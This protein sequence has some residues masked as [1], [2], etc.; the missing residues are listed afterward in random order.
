MI[1][2]KLPRAQRDTVPVIAD[3]GGVL[4]VYGMGADLDRMAGIADDAMIIKIEKE[5]MSCYD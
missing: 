3:D 1:D 5:D 4:A 2:R